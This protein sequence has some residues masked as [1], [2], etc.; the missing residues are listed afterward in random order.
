MFF[1]AITILAIAL[2]GAANAKPTIA[3]HGAVS[4]PRGANVNVGGIFPAS[5]LDAGQSKN[6]A[7]TT[8]NLSGDLSVD[9]VAADF[10]ATLL[11][12][13]ATNCGGCIAFDLSTLPRGTCITTSFGFVSIA[14]SQPSN[15]GLDFGVFVGCILAELTVVNTCFN[16]NTVASSFMLSG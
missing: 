3:L 14:I 1:A 15:S 13:Q 2:V 7:D 4:T 6:E 5:D 9:A 10:P 12:C 8:L 16:L 11:L